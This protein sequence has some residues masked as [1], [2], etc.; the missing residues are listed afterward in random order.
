MVF[1][2]FREAPFANTCAT[3]ACAIGIYCVG[4]VAYQRNVN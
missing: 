2:S 3:F 4:L 1:I